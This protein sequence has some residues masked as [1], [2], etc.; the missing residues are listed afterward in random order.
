MSPVMFRRA[1]A[2]GGGACT[3]RSNASWLMVTWDQPP[4]GQTDMSENIKII[5]SKKERTNDTR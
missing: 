2:G 5:G 3:V 4:S 1:R